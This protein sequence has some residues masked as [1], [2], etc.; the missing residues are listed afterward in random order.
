MIP[1][2][3]DRRAKRWLPLLTALTALGCEDEMMQPPPPAT[4]GG[5]TTASASGKAVKVPTAKASGSAAVA[6]A[7]TPAPTVS[8]ATPTGPLKWSDFGGP[9]VKPDLASGARA[10]AIVPVSEGWDTLKFSLLTVDRV[11]GDEAVFKGADKRELFVPG[12]FVASS[13]P[14]DGLVKGDAVA[15]SAK[16]SRAFARVIAVEGGKVKVRFRYAGDIQELDVEPIEVV[17]LDGSLRFG[18]PASF[19]TLKEEAGGKSKQENHP[20]FYVHTSPAEDKTWLLTS[21]GKPLRVASST[22]KSVSVHVTHKVGDKIWFANGDL[23]AEGQVTSVEDDG[24]RYKLKLA[25]GEETSAP[26]EAVST[27]AK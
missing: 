18:A 12:A 11:E 15:V 5:A 7:S 24:L 26:F 21:S 3:L 27:P 6:S 17:K 14:A 13:K 10:W 1:Q 2:R 19:T 25:S 9:T 16:G 23:F 20:A 4:G 8:I 22:V